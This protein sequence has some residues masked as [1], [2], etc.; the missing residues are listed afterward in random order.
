MSKDDKASS[1]LNPLFLASTLQDSF[2]AAVSTAY[3]VDYFLTIAMFGFHFKCFH[4]PHLLFQFLL[5][6][7]VVC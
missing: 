4:T 6:T 2:F 5:H 7:L 3:L 1:Y